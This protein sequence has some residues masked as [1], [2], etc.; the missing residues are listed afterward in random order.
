V[1]ARHWADAE[2][3]DQAVSYWHRAGQLAA[4]RFA[5]KEA[6]AHHTRGLELLKKVP[7]TMER[8]RVEIQLHN[9]LGVSLTATRGPAPE[10][11]EAYLRARQL[12]ERIGDTRQAYAAVWG[13]WYFNHLRMRL[14]TARDLSYELLELAR[15]EEDKELVL[16][17]HHA[18]WPILL[19]GGELRLCREHAE[20]GLALYD[21]HEHR[22][23]ALRYGGHDP[24]V[25]CR[26]H[27]A[28]AL[29]LLGCAD[30]AVAMARDAV[31]LAGKLAQPFSL[32]MAL[33]RAMVEFGG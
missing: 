15:R 10:V 1:L 17:A 16:Q 29:W 2:L 27:R 19:C 31:C 3:A 4:E 6:I 23:H 7:D 21:Q 26:Y 30:Q 22:C 33:R 8:T 25:C 11:A 9:A 32:V 24:G 14:K 20:Q 5:H 28:L 12:S 13:L 18:A